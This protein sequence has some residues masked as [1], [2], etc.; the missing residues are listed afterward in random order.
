L[1]AL[2]LGNM[3]QHHAFEL[4]VPA[5]HET[6]FGLDALFQAVEAAFGPKSPPGRR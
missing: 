1:T 6:S 2:S 5:I 4:S 3:N